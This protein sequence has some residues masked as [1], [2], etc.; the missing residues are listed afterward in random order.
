MRFSELSLRRLREVSVEGLKGRRVGVGTYEDASA[1]D[2]PGTEKSRNHLRGGA[3][4]SY[5]PKMKVR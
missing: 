1:G 3:K 5:R 2:S 4:V